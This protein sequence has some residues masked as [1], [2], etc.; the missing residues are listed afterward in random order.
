[1]AITSIMGVDTTELIQYLAASL[2][3]YL[4]IKLLISIKNNFRLFSFKD[5]GSS[6]DLGYNDYIK[7]NF[8]IRT[9]DA[10]NDCKIKGMYGNGNLRSIDIQGDGKKCEILRENNKLGIL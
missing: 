6:F 3:L 8:N 5:F 9:D 10:S 1:M 4:V 7:F 2:I